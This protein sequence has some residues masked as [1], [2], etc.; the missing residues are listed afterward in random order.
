MINAMNAANQ[1][2]APPPP[3]APPL[4]GAG[5]L[6][7]TPNQAPA[8]D[9]QTPPIVS[10]QKGVSTQPVSTDLPIQYHGHHATQS[11]QN[12]IRIMLESKNETG[13]EVR[14]LPEGFAFD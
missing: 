14:Q 10:L 12:D 11:S 13:V 1:P 7:P 4:P 2:P 8:V 5:I 3:P 6:V 9:T